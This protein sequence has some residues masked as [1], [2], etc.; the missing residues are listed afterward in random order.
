MD[1]KRTQ[2]VDL[3]RANQYDSQ[4]LRDLVESGALTG[5]EVLCFAG[6]PGGRMHD[7][8]VVGH[9]VTGYRRI[10]VSVR[11]TSPRMRGI[12]KTTPLHRILEIDG[13]PTR[14]STL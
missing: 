3:M 13:E 12:L 6:A 7:A 2:V 8:V 11:I 1:D 10:I 5:A 9:A 14:R 4:K